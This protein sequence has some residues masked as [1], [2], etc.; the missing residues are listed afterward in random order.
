MNGHDQNGWNNQ[1]GIAFRR[2]PA[3]A[4]MMGAEPQGISPDVIAGYSGPGAAKKLQA[5]DLY[6]LSGEYDELPMHSVYL[7]NPFLISTFPIT[8]AQYELFDPEHR[9]YRNYLGF[10]SGDDD[11]VVQVSWYDAVAFCAWLSSLDGRNYRLPTE[12]EWEYAARA[13]TSTAYWTGDTLPEEFHK[14]QRMTWYP[15]PT[16]GP[17]EIEAETPSLKVGTTPANPWGLH[18]VHGLVEEWCLDRYGPYTAE[19]QID[20]VGYADGDF[21]VTRGGSHSTDPYYLR[22]ANRAG[23]LPEDRSWLIGF[24]VAIGE[25]PAGPNIPI[26]VPTSIHIGV[27]PKPPTIWQDHDDRAF[28]LD[29]IP[30]IHIAPDSHGPMFSKHNHCASIIECPNGDVLAT[31]FSCEQEVGREMT[32]VGSRL[33]MGNER[34]D[35]ASLFW[36]APDRNMTG[37]FFWREGEA[38]HYFGALGVGGT[39]GQM[40]IYHRL[41]TNSGATWSPARIIIPDHANGQAQPANLIFRLHD[42]TIVVPGDD[43][44]V[45]GTRLY[46]SH[47]NGATWHIAPGR[48][49]GIHAAVIENDD[50]EIIAFGRMFRP[51]SDYMPMSISSDGGKTFQH[52]F[53]EFPSIRGGQRPVLLKLVEGPLLLC[54][55]ARQ[56]KFADASSKQFTGSGLFGAL[57]Y[58]GGHT[59]PTKRL[60]TVDQGERV[61][62]GGGWTREF[63]MTPVQAEPKGYLTATQGRDGTIHLISS[64]IHYRFN[65][66]WLQTPPPPFAAGRGSHER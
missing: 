24:R 58:D 40:I 20:P 64:K 26:Q 57:S 50:H 28:F 53:T 15:D 63:S 8:N 2:I 47:D 32:L 16:E 30:Y 18:D 29:P 4:F 17:Y 45:N 51:E 39:W 37:A 41:S 31:W 66:A 52:T 10:S 36:D 21:L 13:G 55:F 61:M 5:V 38:I 6:P 49:Q 14:N 3:G 42:G 43:N 11:A 62:D 33:R 23:A 19:D 34:W 59:W 22:S 46:V 12:A 65:L 7:T 48:I 1:D 60:I 44:A 56:M 27:D 25:L 35:A 54:S 9:K